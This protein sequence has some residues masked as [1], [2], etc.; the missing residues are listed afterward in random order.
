MALGCLFWGEMV[1]PGA[2]LVKAVGKAFIIDLFYTSNLNAMRL[3]IYYAAIALMVTML[4]PQNV[5]A[6]DNLQKK[7]QSTPELKN[8]AKNLEESLLA[9]DNIKIAKNYE[10]LATGFV[11]KDD[12]SKAEEYLYK[13]L[14]IYTTVTNN[15]GKAR[16]TRKI[17]QVQELQNNMRAAAQNYK[18]A[19][20]ASVDKLLKKLNANDFSRLKNL[21]KPEVEEKYL[22]QNITLLLKE[23]KREEVADTYIQQ[24]KISLRKSDSL[25][26]MDWYRKAVPFAENVPEKTIKIYSQ[27]AGLHILQK[28]YEEA[29]LIINELLEKAKA[30]K[31]YD[32]QITQLNSLASVYFAIEDADAG[33]NSLKEAYNIASANGKTFEAR[34]SLM[35]LVAY[36]KSVE[37]DKAAIEVYEQFLSNLDRII[38]SDNSLTDAKTFKVTEERI[39]RLESEKTLKDELIARKNTFNYLLLGSVV[40]L[41]LFFAFIVKTLFAIKTKNKEIAL[42][43][44]R[45]EMNPHFIFNSLNSVNHFIAQNNELEANKFLTSYSNLMRNTMENSNKDF[46][47]LSNEISN[48]KKYLELEHLRFRDKFDYNIIVDDNLDPDSTW[49]PNMIIQPHLENAIWHGLRYKE[50]KGLLTLN[51]SLVDNNIVITVDDDGIGITKSQEIKTNNQKLHQSRGITNTTERIALLNDLYKTAIAFIVKEKPA[52]KSGTIVEIK[53]PIINK[54]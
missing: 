46:V 26:A 31:D 12:L 25:M 51:F 15:T 21:G 34:E 42:Q 24:A 13:A 23:N 30:I 36:Y 38:L 54:I 37:D 50:Q 52:P 4:M 20:L 32:T 17:A 40:I 6:Q 16:V 2:D 14:E 41:L 3:T 53:F 9:N 45:R 49:L 18:A 10:L 27:I 48:L 35:N 7:K 39:R 44:L 43:S 33:I 8:A 1:K 29:I 19:E 28:Q 11:D 47:T 5:W 22:N